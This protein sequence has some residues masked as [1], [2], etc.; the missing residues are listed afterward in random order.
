MSQEH[1]KKHYFSSEIFVIPVI[2]QQVAAV[3]WICFFKIGACPTIFLSL[4]RELLIIGGVAAKEQ[5]AV[6]EQGV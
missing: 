5:L 2:Y 4:C 3:S 6:L 1:I